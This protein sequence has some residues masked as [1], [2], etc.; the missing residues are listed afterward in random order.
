LIDSH[1]KKGTFHSSLSLVVYSHT[2]FSAR[3]L[4]L[5]S[6]PRAPFST[7]AL[8]L[9]FYPRTPFSLLGPLLSLLTL[10]KHPR[11]G[12]KTPDTPRISFSSSSSLLLLRRFLRRLVRNHHLPEHHLHLH[13]MPAPASAWIPLVGALVY[14]M[15]V[16][17]L[18]IKIIP[19]W[20]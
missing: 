13:L 9:S 3:T 2:P 7:W 14:I 8:A 6:Y 15:Q 5:S 17:P 20:H 19:W 4:A 10:L 18:I 16:H 1:Y 11:F 12:M